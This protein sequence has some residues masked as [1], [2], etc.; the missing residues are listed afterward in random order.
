MHTPEQRDKHA[1]CGAKKKNGE[2]C[3]KF[4][5]EGTTHPG[6]GTC[7]YHLGA[8]KAH[9]KHAVKV[10][11]QRRAIAFGQPLEI[12]PVEALLSVLHLSA[13]HLAY[14]RAELGEHDDKTTFDAQVL[15]RMWNEER[16]RVARIGKACLDAGVQERR[17]ELAE[18]YGELLAQVLQSIF[19]DLVLN[20]RQQAELPTIVRRHLVA[21]DNQEQRPALTA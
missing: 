1:L 13:G 14:L 17:I 20:K 3:R 2:R 16:D 7:K 21:M 15:L 9:E 5:G 12:E 10:E 8:T 11:A 19:A 6:I 18:R 4:A